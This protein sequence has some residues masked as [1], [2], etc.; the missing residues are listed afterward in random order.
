MNKVLRDGHNFF[1]LVP[2]VGFIIRSVRNYF[3]GKDKSWKWKVR[4][5]VGLFSRVQGSLAD[6]V[7]LRITN[8]GT[9][10]KAL[11]GFQYTFDTE[12]RQIPETIMK[13]GDSLDKSEVEYALERLPMDGVV[14]DAGAG[15]GEYAMHLSAKGMVHSFEPMETQYELLRSNIKRNNLAH[16]IRANRY[17]LWNESGRFGITHLNVEDN[18]LVKAED[19]RS[20]ET[21]HALR[22]DEYFKE[23]E[24]Y[25]VDLVKADIQG[26]EFQMIMGLGKYMESHPALLLEIVPRCIKRFGYEYSELFEYLIG[27]GY[28]YVGFY[29]DGTVHKEH[30]D[31]MIKHS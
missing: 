2:G 9:F 24:I 18:R 13:G 17:A 20:V 7:E 10:V 3:L 6:G 5:L 31:E 11:D 25:K 29:E 4:D 28:G 12:G 26:A 1:S 30:Y 19:K 15:V 21:I 23:K 27:L 8:N 16:R 22:L 14:V